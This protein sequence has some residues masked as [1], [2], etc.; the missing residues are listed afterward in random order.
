MGEGGGQIAVGV[1]LGSGKAIGIAANRTS[2]PL[3]GLPELVTDELSRVAPAFAQT[4]KFASHVL[5]R[6]WRFE[7]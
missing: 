6:S 4:S 5:R 2:E 7:S 3:S 1:G